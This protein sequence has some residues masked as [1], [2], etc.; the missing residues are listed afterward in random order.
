MQN[1]G[2]TDSPAA[3]SVRAE[4]KAPRHWK[5]ARRVVAT[6]TWA[7]VVWSELAAQTQPQPLPPVPDGPEA[8]SPGDTIP[9]TD[10]ILGLPFG[11]QRDLPMPQVTE[12]DASVDAEPPWYD[13]RF[14]WRPE[15]WD[16]SFE[17]GIAGA[18]G[19]AETLDLRAG[20]DWKR[21]WERAKLAWSITYAKSRNAVTQTKHNALFNARTD[22]NF[23]DSPWSWFVKTGVEYDEFKAF[24]LRLVVNSG[25]SYAWFKREGL[26]LSSRFG[27][28]ASREFDGPDNSW[29]PE[30][31]FGVSYEH[32]W[33]KRQKFIFDADY[34]P[35]WG[36]FMNYRLVAKASWEMLL[37]E[38]S[39]LSL[40][41]SATDRYDSTPHDRR[42]N[43]IDY[44]LLL[45]WKF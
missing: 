30:A 18:A 45:L 31:V 41:L 29:V 21:E 34:Y 6:L 39:N 44:A 20:T 36:D 10:A 33:S 24:D 3:G 27:A 4:R 40:K 14:W 9:G 23:G 13:P 26:T 1:S 35:D 19:N 8:V 12:D 38:A 32:Q 5:A 37:D 42:P 17:I 7:A 43:D 11:N 15:G 2:T 25:L 28:G 22:V 16:N